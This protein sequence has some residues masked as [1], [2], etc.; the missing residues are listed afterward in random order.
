MR[1]WYPRPTPFI[2]ATTSRTSQR[3]QALGLVQASAGKA[4]RYCFSRADSVWRTVTSAACV[5]MR[6]SFLMMAW[7]QRAPLPPLP[8]GTRREVLFTDRAHAG[9][10]PRPAAGAT[11]EWTL[12]AVG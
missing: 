8:L 2:C 10:E 1:S 9:S 7:H 3:A 4:P 5:A 12:E 6:L 11:L